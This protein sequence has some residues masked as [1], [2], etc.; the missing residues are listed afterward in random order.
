MH[1]I[2]QKFNV[3]R[4]FNKQYFATFIYTFFLLINVCGSQPLKKHKYN[5]QIINY[6]QFGKQFFRTLY[7]N[8]S[9]CIYI[10]SIGG[11]IDFYLLM[12]NYHIKIHAHL[13]ES[14]S[15]NNLF[16]MLVSGGWITGW[17]LFLYRF[18][19]SCSTLSPQHACN[20][21]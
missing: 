6:M 15:L 4:R 1:V 10:I 14:L 5:M 2:S 8:K 3:K 21:N 7:Q 9:I 16:Y 12:H 13:H 19:F 17:F 20:F 11:G 18:I